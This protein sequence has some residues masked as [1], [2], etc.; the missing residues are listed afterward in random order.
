M[1]L[2]KRGSKTNSQCISK[3]AGSDESRKLHI[4]LCEFIAQIAAPLICRVPT[5]AANRART[6]W[7]KNEEK[8]KHIGNYKA[9]MITRVESVDLGYC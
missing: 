7:R 3:T 8:T 4:W 2:W 6:S 1:N 9:T 5:S